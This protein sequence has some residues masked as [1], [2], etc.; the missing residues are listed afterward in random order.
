MRMDRTITVTKADLENIFSEW[1]R[2]AN[3]KDHRPRV[4]Q[5]E[6]PYSKVCADYFV[7]LYN[8]LQTDAERTLP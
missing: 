2:R 3:D 1:T 4:G 8:D 5:D 7:E 6:A